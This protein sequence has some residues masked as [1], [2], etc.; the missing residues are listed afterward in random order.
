MLAEKALNASRTKLPPA[1][2]YMKLFLMRETRSVT[3]TRSFSSFCCAFF[4][5]FSFSFSSFSRLDLFFITIDPSFKN[6]L[7]SADISYTS[8]VLYVKS[9]ETPFLQI[10]FVWLLPLFLKPRF[11][12][13]TLF[14]YFVLF[15]N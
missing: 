8:S 6:D 13:A 14:S 9:T 2:I 4:T 10:F 3:V 7:D 5:S 15:V 12:H 11:A 1:F